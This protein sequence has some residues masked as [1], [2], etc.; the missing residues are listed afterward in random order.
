[1]SA[2]EGLEP[3]HGQPP[4]GGTHVSLASSWAWL[5]VWRGNCTDWNSVRSRLAKWTGRGRG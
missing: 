3:E 5:Y 4:L 2:K 1:M